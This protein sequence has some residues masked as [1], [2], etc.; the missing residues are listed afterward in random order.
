MQHNSNPIVRLLG[1]TSIIAF[2]SLISAGIGFLITAIIV[3]N[4]GIEKYGMLILMLTL[5]VNR[6]FMS[7]FDF[8]MKQAVSKRIA[9]HAPKKQW[10][11]I[12]KIITVG[13]VLSL[14]TGGFLSV[15]TINLNISSMSGIDNYETYIVF[16]SM[17]KLFFLSYAIQYV[18]N[19][20]LGIFEGFQRYDISKGI[21]V[22]SQIIQLACISLLVYFN[23][24]FDYIVLIYLGIYLAIFILNIVILKSIF[25][26]WRLTLNVSVYELN[27]VYQMLK[28][29][30]PLQ[31]SS[32]IFNHYPKLLILFFLD[33]SA[34]GVYDIVARI[35]KFFK[36][37]SGF[38][39]AA[40]MPISSE[41]YSF[42]KNKEIGQMYKYGFRVNIYLMTP[43]LSAGVFFASEIYQLWV[44]SS[45]YSGY[46]QIFMVWNFLVP[47]VTFGGPLLIGMNRELR[48]MRNVSWIITIISISISVLLIQKLEIVG[49]IY[50][51]LAGFIILPYVFWKYTKIFNI[52]I[53]SVLKNNVLVYSCV[54]FPFSV[55][56]IFVVKISMVS[57]ISAIVIWCLLYWIAIYI[58]IVDNNEK[59]I[60][61][62]VLEK[63]LKK[64]W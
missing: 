51:Y 14:V 52:S 3:R 20:F 2:G 29:L 53:I 6:G 37:L 15:I 33:F 22:F 35:P 39:S 8:G 58:L 9:Q 44:G 62:Q 43:I 28:Y 17:L 19:I 40:F 26:N 12:N 21:E 25:P 57:I 46:M 16:F 18:N 36:T 27:K 24:T 42:G 4:F 59:R 31:S 34:L 1:Y 47:Y 48:F 13:L 61:S 11:D 32:L 45:Q 38:I 56:S 54:L 10:K 49:L 41:M 60:V 55:F 30:F 5:S 7:L 23:W 50:G 63:F 64:V